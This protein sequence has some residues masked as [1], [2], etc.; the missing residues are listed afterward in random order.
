MQHYRNKLEKEGYTVHYINSS[1]QEG[2]I[3]ILIKQLSKEKIREL[4]YTDPVDNWLERR[5]V[6]S[7]KK[8]KIILQKSDSPNFLNTVAETNGFFDQKKT[9][10]QTDFY[11]W[12]RKQ[13][14]ILTDAQLKPEGGK[15]T[16]DADNRKPFPKNET[17]PVI[18]FPEEDEIG[19]AH[20]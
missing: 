3:R 16:Y 2:D 17:I 5:I 12:Q 4:C 14:A 19:R 11:I 8:H 7:A 18:S 13:R 20:V 9:Y 6:S 1:K 10:F 15:W